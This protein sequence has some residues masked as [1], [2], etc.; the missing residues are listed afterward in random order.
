MTHLKYIENF[1]DGEIVESLQ[2]QH[3]ELDRD[4]DNLLIK[5]LSYR[6]L[7]GVICNI[8]CDN[9]NKDSVLE[10]VSENGYVF[11]D[12]MSLYGHEN[13]IIRPYLRPMSSMTEEELNEW[14]SISND[15]G[16]GVTEGLVGE[17][18][19]WL[20]ANHFDY[21][22]LI[23]KGLAIEITKENNPYK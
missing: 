1:P 4:D 10:S 7:Y 15:G 16:W 2:Q 13:Y 19:D 11:K 18:I 5:D 21:R 8:S 17:C 6:V 22:G 3:N 14:Y 9:F 23:E 20:N 12:N